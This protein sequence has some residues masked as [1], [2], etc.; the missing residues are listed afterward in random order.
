MTFGTPRIV[1]HRPPPHILC[2]AISI[3]TEWGPEKLSL[4]DMELTLNPWSFISQLM[5]G[6]SCKGPKRLNWWSGIRIKNDLIASSHLFGLHLIFNIIDIICLSI[7]PFLTW[8][9]M[10]SDAIVPPTRV[11]AIA[12]HV[13]ALVAYFVDH[14]YDWQV[15]SRLS[16]GKSGVVLRNK[17]FQIAR[18][19]IDHP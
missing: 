19:A 1:F 9:L 7:G 11:L 13:C 5:F 2:V 12:S 10:S 16:T 8:S 6:F 4:D 15:S 14:M 3:D 17:S 18:E